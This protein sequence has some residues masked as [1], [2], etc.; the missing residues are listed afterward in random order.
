MQELS[1]WFACSS[2]SVL[3]AKGN[4]EGKG[5]ALGYLDSVSK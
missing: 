2:Y 4:E 5:A 3:I 1:N